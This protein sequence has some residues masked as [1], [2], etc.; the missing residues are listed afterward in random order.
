MI[1]LAH[2]TYPGILFALTLAFGFWVSR[3]GKPYNGLLF[4]I[5]KLLA[6]GAVID[7]AI[8]FSKAFP[9]TGSLAILIAALV[10]AAACGVALF[11]S[12]ALMSAGK[13]DYIVL[14]TIHRLA[15]PL[16]GLSVA[17]AIYLLSRQP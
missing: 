8:Q 14:R 11:A 13:L 16:L 1:S 10:V 2:F 12:G 3:L 9:T 6:L 17:A 5:H 4:N 15:P 7:P